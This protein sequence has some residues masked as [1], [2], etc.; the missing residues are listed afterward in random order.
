MAV[1][2]ERILEIAR[3][4]P[5]APRVFADLDKLLRDTNSGLDQIGNLIKRDQ[6]LAAHI[7]RVSNSVAYGGEQKTASVEEA[8]ARVGFSEIFRIVGEV[9]GARLAE[10]ALKYYGIDAEQ[11]REHMLYSAF[12][13][14][15]L[16][17]QCG[18]NERSAYTA[19][20]MRPLGMLVV[21][22]LA[23]GYRKVDPYHP[24]QDADYMAWEGRIFGLPSFEVAAMV[25][26]E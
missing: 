23:D 25:L 11:L 18:L 15:S 2:R 8:V 5:P 16:A 1:T 6:S 10:R 9:A 26:T 22:R 13:C 21:D 17:L 24:A 7:L 19:G 4:L 3:T 14:E 20:L 12:I